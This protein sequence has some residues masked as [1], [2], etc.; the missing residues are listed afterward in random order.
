MLYNLI[1]NKRDIWLHSEECTIRNVLDYIERRGMLRDAQ[2]EA[3]KTYLYLKVKC[4]NKPLWELFCRGE[5]N[6]LDL[7]GLYIPAT[8]R[9]A[10]V[11][12][13]GLAALYEYTL[14]HDRSGKEITP[15]LRAYISEH[16]D[17]IDA[18]QVFRN[19][20]Y[21]VSYT[22]YLFSLPMGTQLHLYS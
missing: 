3:I 6:T 2:V 1:H 7:N 16:A 17:E 11:R 12:D 15:R 14:Q 19:I 9:A 13:K 18:K 4:Q 22:D 20:F 5:F 21:G 10:M 8:A